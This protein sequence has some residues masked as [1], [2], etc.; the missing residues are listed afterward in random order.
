MAE[1]FET[2]PSIEFA[3]TGIRSERSGSRDEMTTE[4]GIVART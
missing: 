2:P 4:K 1:Y 3:A